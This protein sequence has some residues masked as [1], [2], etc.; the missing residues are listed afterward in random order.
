MGFTHHARDE[1]KK[2]KKKK[3]IQLPL[4]FFSIIPQNKKQNVNFRLPLR[5]C[6]QYWWR[7]KKK[8]FSAELSGCSE[9][10]IGIPG[11]ERVLVNKWT[12]AFYRCRHFPVSFPGRISARVLQPR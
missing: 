4:I 1:E 6:H 7:S 5:N 2:E 11:A 12:E 8:N 9:I 10:T 3:A